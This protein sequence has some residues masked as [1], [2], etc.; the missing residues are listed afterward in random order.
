MVQLENIMPLPTW[1][2]QEN[3]EQEERRLL[4]DLYEVETDVLVERVESEF[5]QPMVAPRSMHK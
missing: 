4:G 2:H 3:P 5:C 1:Q